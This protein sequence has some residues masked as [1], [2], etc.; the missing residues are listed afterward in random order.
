MGKGKQ[1]YASQVVELDLGDKMEVEGKVIAPIVTGTSSGKTACSGF[2]NRITAL[3]AR[4]EAMGV[5]IVSQRFFDSLVSARTCKEL[6]TI[7]FRGKEDMLII[8]RMTN[9]IPIP[10]AFDQKK[11]LCDMVE[12][13][14]NKIEPRIAFKI[15]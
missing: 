15:V 2:D 10:Q 1:Q 3:E 7:A 5:D 9:S 6:D 4:L 8:T 12:E 11:C 13:M 14:L